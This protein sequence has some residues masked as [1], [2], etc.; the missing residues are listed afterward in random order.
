MPGCQLVNAMLHPPSR[1]Q[2]YHFHSICV[3]TVTFKLLCFHINCHLVLC[4]LVW[5]YPSLNLL[6]FIDISL[7]FAGKSRRGFK[8]ILIV[9]LSATASLILTCLVWIAC[10]QKEKG[11]LFTIRK[12]AAD[13]SKIEEVLKQYDSLAPQRYNYSDLKKITK[14][15]KDKLGEGGYGMVFKGILQDGRMVAVKLLT[16]TKGNGEE[17]LN[18]VISIGRTSH[19]NIVSL[20]GFCLQ[21][22]KRALVYEY[23]ANG[24]LDNYIYSE[25]SKIVVGWEKLQQIAIGIARGLEYLHCRCNTRIIHFDIKPHNILLDEDFCPK[26]AD[27]GLAKLCRLK[28]SALSMAEARGT[29]GFIAPEVFSRGFGVVS[30]KSDVYSYGMLLLEL[31]GGR[32][33]VN[34]TTTHSS[35]TYFPNRIY[36]CLVEDLQTHALITEAEEITKLMTIVGLWCIQTNPENRPSISRV[37]EMLEKNF[38]EL[39]VPPKPFLS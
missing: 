3:I 23:M 24:S 31:V 38:N 34:Q 33:H 16:G 8:L 30:T 10:H 32:R 18:E 37:I 36:D 35:E 15:F 21:G 29:V 7:H 12:Y 22:S 14:S 39:E 2:N 17:F 13:E 27:F 9:S 1:K 11:T 6:V 26:V 25:E 4:R 19:V 28:D 5:T 20:L